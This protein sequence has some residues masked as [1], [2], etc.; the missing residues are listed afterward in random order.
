MK[1]SS[2]KKRS[3]KIG[4][5]I[6]SI[7]ILITLVFSYEFL[8]SR[9]PQ[10]S[11]EVT[12]RGLS[13]PVEVLR[14]Q[15][16]IPHITAKNNLDAFRTLGFIMASERLFQMEVSRRLAE[17]ELAELLGEKALGSDKLF[18]NLGLRSESQKTIERK[19]KDH[20]FDPEMLAEMTAYYDGVNEFIAT[21]PMRV[22]FKLLGLTP[23]PFSMVDGQSFVGLMAFSFG[24]AIMTE[25]LLTK[26][27]TRIGGDLTEDLRNEK[28]PAIES[29]VVQ[30]DKFNIDQS[31][32]K[33]LKELE[34]G[35]PLFEGSNGWLL[36]AS[37]SKSGY[38]ILANDP[39]IAYTHPGIWFEAHIKTPTYETYG[40][41]LSLIPFPILA[42][43]RERAWGLTMSL[44]DDMDMYRESID[45]KTETYKFKGKDLPMTK[46]EEIIKV[47]K[48]QDVKLTVYRT[49][50]GPILDYAF[51][52][53]N[54]NEKSLALQWPFYNPENDPMTSVFKMGRAQNMNEFKAA[55]ATGKAPGLNILYADKKNI[56]WWIFGEVWK[57][58]SGIKTDFILNGEKGED[59]ILGTL[60]EAEKP[61]SENPA[62]GVIISAN[63]RPFGYP[64]DARGDWQPDDRYKTIET[65]LSHNE[66]WSPEQTME[67]QTLNMNF[68]NKAI[69]ETLL[70]ET[71][72]AAQEDAARY[73]PPMEI[74]KNWNLTSDVDSAGAAIYYSWTREIQKILL[75][76]L[77]KDEQEVF[78]K[79]PNGW[80]FFKRVVMNRDSVWWKKFDRGDV[81]R[82][83]FVIAIT[84]LKKKLGKD[85]NSWQW[86]EIHTLEFQHPFGRI[87]PLNYLFNL[88]PYPVPGATQEVNNQKVTSFEGN[89]LVKAGPSTRRIIDFS[90]PEKSWGI[91]PEGNSGHIM[92]PFYSNQVKMFLEGKYREQLLDLKADSK[93][94]RFKMSFVPAH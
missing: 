91:L 41:F 29:V 42:H 38:P 17:G 24:I 14:D 88:G 1:T 30:N 2:G 66:L 77:T 34:Q 25:P 43:N 33:I 57:K 83:S 81:F 53:S 78:A 36:A 16:G 52:D 19:L 90:N 48:A 65:V 9:V 32:V 84:D 93:E 85:E 40:H 22:E 49:H 10:M 5:F 45:P 72:F 6:L 94:V 31:V 11:G 55:V 37:R 7:L 13:A 18:R 82:K 92:S 74:L 4:L 76:D 59:E 62:S 54:S 8:N 60:S 68:E 70:Q 28:V 56:G 75:K 35:F 20:S 69:L 67:L 44:T 89:F 87:K 26:L 47:K 3:L 61:H 58:R 50:H 63:T 23:K 12:I 21:G 46:T 79:V 71:H 15:N 86:G 39:H 73:L 64:K 80:I 27:V 51:G